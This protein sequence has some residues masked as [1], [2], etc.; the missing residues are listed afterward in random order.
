MKKPTVLVILDGFG[1]R[2]AKEYNAIA[3]DGA[4]NIARLMEQYPNTLLEASGLAVG[5]PAGQMGNSE[6]GHLNMGAGRVVYQELTRITKAIEDGDFF[7]N[8]AFIAAMDGAKAKNAK[9][10]L[11][12]LCSDG[13]VHS[14]MTHIYALVEMAKRRGLKDVFLHCF[15][16]GRD[17]PPQSGGE[18]IARLEAELKAIGCGKIATVSGRYY[19]MDRDNRFERLEKAYAALTYGKGETA[20]SAAEAMAQ[21]YAAGVTDEFVLPTVILQ[22][23][24][25]TATVGANDSV[26][27]FNFRPDR[28]RELTRA[29]LFED[30]DGFER[31]NGY[32]PLTYV[33]M[34]QYDKAFEDK[35]SVAFKPQSLEN[36]LGEYIAKKGLKQLRIAETEKY[37]HVTFFF[38]GGVEAPNHGEDR[39]LI[40]SPKV[41]TYD[42]QPEMS[43]Q[44][45]SEQAVR[46]INSG[47]YDVVILN[48][49]NPDMV[50]HTGVME[51]AVKAV[52]TVDVCTK[53]VVDAVLYAG[54]RCILTADHGNCELMA[55]NGAPFT[56]HTTSPVPFVLIDENMKNAVLR[57]DGKLCDIAPTLLELMGVEKP[58]AMTGQSLIVH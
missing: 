7:E 25:P 33:S 49:A 13:G 10:H 11:F 47:E 57:K 30:F 23:G 22:N 44:E 5:L 19:A 18:Y 24:K 17:V 8:P 42:M 40:P 21:S 9:L 41:A 27:F 50:G 38:N 20:Q 16:D 12:G 3:T 53:Q 45:V 58:E 43:A 54:G 52:H 4:A 29:Y 48:F 36:T 26:I 28:A 56:A 46:R 14:H 1:C 34:T 51:A 2:S 6:V 35:L 39:V 55:E 32:F 37:A 15:M 31:Q